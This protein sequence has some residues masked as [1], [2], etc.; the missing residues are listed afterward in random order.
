M[1]ANEPEGLNLAEI[2]SAGIET[3]GNIKRSNLQAWLTNV[4][5]YDGESC[6]NNNG[7]IHITDFLSGWALVESPNDGANVTTWIDGDVQWSEGSG[8]RP[9]TLSFKV[10]DGSVFNSSYHTVESEHGDH[11]NGFCNTWFLNNISLC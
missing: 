5:C 9:L 2:G 8:V 4:N 10:E 7:T 3:D 11:K 6:L 1:A